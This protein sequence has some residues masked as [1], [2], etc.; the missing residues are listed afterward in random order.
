MAGSAFFRRRRPCFEGETDVEK[1]EMKVLCIFFGSSV[2]PEYPRLFRFCVG[3]VEL[4]EG[5]FS[6]V[7][8]RFLFGS[9]TGILTSFP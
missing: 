9:S 8:S 6:G 4:V 1:G 3:A 7:T 2:R 5:K